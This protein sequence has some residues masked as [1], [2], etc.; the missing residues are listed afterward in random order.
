VFYLACLNEV[1]DGSGDLFDGSVLVD[2]V[3]VKEVDGVGLQTLERAFDDLLDMVGT[4]IECSPLSVIVGIG[5]KTEFCGD[6]DFFAEWSEGF[7]DDLFVN[8]G[9]VDFGGVKESDA[10]LNSAA[11]ELDGF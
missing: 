7:A 5:L 2:A 9:A 10:A 3:L 8:V 4:A 6:D 11:D 1:F